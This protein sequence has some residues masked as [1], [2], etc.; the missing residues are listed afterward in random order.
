M[1]REYVD[2]LGGRLPAPQAAFIEAAIRRAK[3]VKERAAGDLRDFN[4][5]ERA[6]ILADRAEVNEET[7][8]NI[9]IGGRAPRTNRAAT[10]HNQGDIVSGN[11]LGYIFAGSALIL[12]KNGA[13]A[14]GL[15]PA[16][17]TTAPAPV[18]TAQTTKDKPAK[19]GA[20]R[21][22][23]D[24]STP[25]GMAE[26]RNSA[27]TVQGLTAQADAAEDDN[28]REAFLERAR[29]AGTAAERG[30][31][32]FVFKIQQEHAG[33]PIN[34]IPAAG[35]SVR[36]KGMSGMWRVKAMVAAAQREMGAVKFAE[37][38]LAREAACGDPRHQHS[39]GPAP[40]LS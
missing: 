7:P 31:E 29:N 2:I 18:A 40:V 24:A 23:E 28:I 22:F 30:L 34:A 11:T 17:S 35:M 37:D 36:L 14:L 8:P 12:L 38:Q 5:E 16:F 20:A 26:L 39:S 4:N 15:M 9:S 32:G 25:P 13:A 6:D 19:T 33:T 1:Q 21:T 3:S 27:E 10:R